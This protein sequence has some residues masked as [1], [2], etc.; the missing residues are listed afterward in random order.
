VYDANGNQINNWNSQSFINNQGGFENRQI[1]ISNLENQQQYLFTILAQNNAGN[2]Q[3]VTAQCL[4]CV[5]PTA[6]TNLFENTSRRTLNSL[7]LEWNSG[8]NTGA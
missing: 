7:G 6:P 8:F 4:P 3:P 1:T 2:S 5:N